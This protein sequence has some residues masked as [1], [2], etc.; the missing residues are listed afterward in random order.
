M[1]EKDVLLFVRDEVRSAWT[2]ELLLL[3]HRAPK[4]WTRE[5]LVRELRATDALIAHNLSLLQSAGLIGATEADHYVYQ[6][7]SPEVAER[8]AALAELYAHKPITVLRTIFTS[9]NDKIRS[10]ADA[11]LFKKPEQR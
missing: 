6:P 7:R 9:P 4:A 11:F 5:A 2:L 1:D 3:F 10:F 8:V